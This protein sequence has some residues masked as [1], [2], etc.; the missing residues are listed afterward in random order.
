MYDFIFASDGYCEVCDDNNFCGPCSDEKESVVTR[1]VN[2]RVAIMPNAKPCIGRHFL[3]DTIVANHKMTIKRC[4]NKDG[5]SLVELDSLITHYIL[6]TKFIKTD[7]TYETIQII[8]DTLGNKESFMHTIRKEKAGDI[9]RL[10][11]N[12]VTLDIIHSPNP[13]V[14]KVIESAR[15]TVSFRLDPKKDFYDFI[16]NISALATSTDKLKDKQFIDSS[17]VYLDAIRSKYFDCKRH[18]GEVE[19]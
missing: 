18:N 17:D 13:C 15:D 7:S 1:T 19:K 16:N 14:F 12:G 6:S 10:I 4:I 3:L 5:K 2:R 8:T 9:M 11:F